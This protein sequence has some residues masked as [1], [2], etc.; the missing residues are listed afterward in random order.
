MHEVRDVVT[1]KMKKKP[2]FSSGTFH[3]VVTIYSLKT[4]LLDFDEAENSIFILNFVSER[5]HK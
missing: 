4:F 3:R 5:Q 2:H 1:K